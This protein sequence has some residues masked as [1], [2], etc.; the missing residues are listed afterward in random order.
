MFWQI[1]QMLFWAHSKRWTTRVVSVSIIIVVA[2]SILK[3][4][5]SS[6]M[7][8]V[9]YNPCGGWIYLLEWKCGFLFSPIIWF[10]HAYNYANYLLIV[11]DLFILV[12]LEIVV[13]YISVCVNI[14]YLPKDYGIMVTFS[15]DGVIYI[16]KTISGRSAYNIFH[17]NII[18]CDIYMAPYSAM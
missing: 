18:I 7:T 4:H 2:A 14:T 17:Y 10:E 5:P 9:R 13:Q 1:S 6:L 8:R 16:R 15:I 11:F 12:S 3:F